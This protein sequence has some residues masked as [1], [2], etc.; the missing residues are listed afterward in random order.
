[1]SAS[2]QLNRIVQL[3]A[4]LTRREREA[5]PPATLNELAE[6]FG[7]T[8]GQIESD[9]RTLT[10]LGD[11]PG[12]DWLLS[13]RVSQEGETV[14]LS[15]GGPFRRP[16]RFTPD[17]A[18]ALEV[19][20]ATEPDG[21]KLGKTL[22]GL[23]AHLGDH[24]L[25]VAVAPAAPSLGDFFLWAAAHS[26][27]VEI[28]Y[29]G[30]GAPTGSARVIQPHQVVGF[31]GRT[32]VVAW[33][34][35]VRQWRHFRLDRVV[36]AMAT[37]R[38]FTPRDDFQPVHRPASIFREPDDGANDVRVMF[39]AAIARWMLERYPEAAQR[40][41]G[42]AV[43]TY[44]VADVQWLVRRVLQYGPEA[45]VLEPEAYREAVKRAVG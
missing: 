14:R 24:E 2:E 11:D 3:V 40:S 39:S 6:R 16:I 21:A 32:Y 26:N 35:R 36:D 29:A 38:A 9:I 19:G 45:Q 41:D 28:L 37:G 42:S 12:A 7:T 4:E 44:R 25:P 34:E 17:E 8:V 27:C 18:L 5:H 30:E 15:S 13:L 43:V 10:L 23:F 1:M 31:E 33:C 20:L 22:A